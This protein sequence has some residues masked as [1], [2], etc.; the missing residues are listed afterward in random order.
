MSL[1]GDRARE[2]AEPLEREFRHKVLK[3][4]E[5]FRA[6]LTEEAAAKL[7]TMRPDAGGEGKY[8]PTMISTGW[9]VVLDGW[10][11]AMR[12]GSGKPDI[13]PG[14]TLALIARRIPKP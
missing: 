12:F 1:V 5:R 3:I 10:P 7:G 11:V 14:E 9:W 8:E 2:L 6:L 4:E 13:Q